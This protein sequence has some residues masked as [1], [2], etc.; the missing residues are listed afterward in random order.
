MIGEDEVK[1]A[2]I[3][4]LNEA[5]G[6]PRGCD[7]V[8]G[9]VDIINPPGGA[10]GELDGPY[11]GA[12]DI[13]DVGGGGCLGLGAPGNGA[14]GGEFNALEF[15]AV[16]GE[17]VDIEVEFPP[18]PGAEVPYAKLLHGGFGGGDQRAGEFNRANG[19]AIGVGAQ[20]FKGKVV[21]LI[22]PGDSGGV[23]SIGILDVI[24]GSTTNEVE[25]KEVLPKTI[26]H[27]DTDTFVV[28]DPIVVE[29]HREDIADMKDGG[30]AAHGVCGAVF[31]GP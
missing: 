7:E 18:S 16:D 10:A 28:G 3:S 23:L 1:G 20:Q 27:A 29:L 12:E 9:V 5:H 8:G 17:V 31:I 11:A 30:E 26:L 21:S 25:F 19:K 15:D 2:A 14:L 6:H 13:H 24:V 22:A 4:G